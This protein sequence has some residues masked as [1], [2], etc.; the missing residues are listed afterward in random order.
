MLLSCSLPT[1]E[2]YVTTTS[3]KLKIQHHKFEKMANTIKQ[4]FYFQLENFMLTLL[5]Y[6]DNR[7]TFVHTTLWQPVLQKHHVSQPVKI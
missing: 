6:S 1:I 5:I 7:G 2:I 3:E 4:N